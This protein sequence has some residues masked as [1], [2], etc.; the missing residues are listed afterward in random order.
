MSA[1]SLLIHPAD[2]ML[3]PPS[4]AALA[5]LLADAGLIGEPLPGQPGTFR[6]GEGFLRHVTFLGCSPHLVFDPPQNGGDDFS[7]VALL[8]PYDSPRLIVGD[9]TL[10]PRCRVC[11]AA[12]ADWRAEALTWMSHPASAVATCAACE[13]LQAPA[14]LDWRE[15]AA[16]AR[17]FV[18]VRNVFPGECVPGDELLARLDTLTGGPWRFAWVH[19]RRR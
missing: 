19:R 11:R 10:A 14:A 15:T 8:G 4:L 17:V 6:V 2:P 13:A 7:H 3:P 12:F 18:D 5:G 1:G 16:A 9:N